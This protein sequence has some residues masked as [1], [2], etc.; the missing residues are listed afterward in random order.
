MQR[1]Y[2]TLGMARSVRLGRWCLGIMAICP[3]SM[4]EYRTTAMSDIVKKDAG[5]KRG[6]SAQRANPCAPRVE[7]PD[8]EYRRDWEAGVSGQGNVLFLFQR[9]ELLGL[10]PDCRL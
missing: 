3:V 2:E 5:R 9:P 4:V 7:A 1:V 8:H 10:A 6:R